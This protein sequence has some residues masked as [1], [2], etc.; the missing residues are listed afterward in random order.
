MIL[1]NGRGD[2]DRLP[3]VS[4]SPTVVSNLEHRRTICDRIKSVKLSEK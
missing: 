4:P 2:R 3:S 1:I